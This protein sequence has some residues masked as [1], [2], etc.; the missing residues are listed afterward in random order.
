MNLPTLDNLEISGKT[1]ILRGDLDVGLHDNIVLDDSR[2]QVL[3]SLIPKIFAKG[4]KKLLL[5]GH[6]GRPEKPDHTF[7]LKPLIN[8]F[9]EK[10]SEAVT[11]IEFQPGK[12]FYLLHDAIFRS[13]SRLVLL[14]NLRFWKEEEKGNETFAEELAYV[15]G[16]YV[17]EAFGSSHR[18]HASIVALPKAVK[19][20]SP[21]SLAAG[22]R[23]QAEI[24]NL[25]RVFEKPKKPTVTIIG[26]AKE[27]KLSYL[28]D[29]KHFSYKILL[30]GRLPEFIPESKKEP[31]VLVASLNP[32]KEDITVHSTQEF[33]KEISA[34]GTIVVSGP[35]GRFEDSGHRLGTERIFRAIS[36]NTSAFRVAG[37][38]DTEKAISELHL[39]NAFDWISVGGGAMLEF[40]AK[41]T[42]PG[43]E[44]LK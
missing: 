38:G 2:L 30:A 8:Y 22:P 4:A 41:G 44:A 28:D 1:V 24:E 15:A 27:D 21:N 11:F 5:I 6:K 18:P 10:L 37:G 29:F 23:F 42:L 31:K 14:E 33:E 3:S 40:L 19:N 35:I 7:S 13:K 43:I 25:S 39:E 36:A 20:R 12:R 17:N 9:Q 32:D 16:A 26:G 34:A